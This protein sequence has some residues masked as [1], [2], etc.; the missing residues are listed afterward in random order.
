MIGGIALAFFFVGRRASSLTGM[1]TQA[2]RLKIRALGDRASTG[3]AFCERPD[4]GFF[5]RLS[6]G[7]RRAWDRHVRCPEQKH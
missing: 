5:F 3:R 4:A 7:V 6:K 1:E 2:R